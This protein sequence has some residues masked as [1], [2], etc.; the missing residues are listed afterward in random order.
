MTYHETKIKVRF[1][2]IDAYQV[3]WHG[4]YVASLEVGRNE[5]AG[6]FDLEAFHLAA[7]G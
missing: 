5:L 7:L 3:A 1:N 6:Q 2:E 4:H